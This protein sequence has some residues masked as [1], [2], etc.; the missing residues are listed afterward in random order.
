[1]HAYTEIT[2]F[3]LSNDIIC[4]IILKAKEIGMEDDLYIP[5][6]PDSPDD[7]DDVHNVLAEDKKDLTSDELK[8][9]INQLEP[10]QQKELIALM[11][12]GRGD[13]DKDQWVDA[14][15]EADNVVPGERANFLLEKTMLADYLEEG[16]ARFGGSCEI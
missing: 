16:L 5:G 8:D 2:M 9:A 10:D 11:F 3:N 6:D 7:E 4:D 14:L 1:M 13:Y 15:K 12:V